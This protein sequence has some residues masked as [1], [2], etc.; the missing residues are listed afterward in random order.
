MSSLTRYGPVTRHQPP[1]DPYEKAK[2]RLKRDIQ[3]LSGRDDDKFDVEAELANAIEYRGRDKA[4]RKELEGYLFKIY[5]KRQ[6]ASGQT[7]MNDLGFEARGLLHDDQPALLDQFVNKAVTEPR[8]VV[9]VRRCVRDIASKIIRF[10][11]KLKGIKSLVGKSHLKFAAD[12][13]INISLGNAPEKDVVDY[14]KSEANMPCFTTLDVKL[15]TFIK[16]FLCR[17]ASLVTEIKEGKP[18][19]DVMEK[20][21]AKIKRDATP[22][23][24]NEDERL[25]ASLPDG[26]AQDLVTL[27]YNACSGL[28]GAM[29]KFAKQSKEMSSGI[30]KSVRGTP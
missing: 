24:L 30:P 20:L 16:A 27:F 9:E 4:G 28:A 22:D 7:G 29:S 3:R 6:T 23:K 1:V 14:V 15:L 11:E 8:Q 25:V 18:C 13:L 17:D 21:S 19:W 12:G 5:P 2:E 10:D 26:S